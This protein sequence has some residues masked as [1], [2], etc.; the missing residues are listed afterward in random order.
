MADFDVQEIVES[1]KKKGINVSDKFEPMTKGQINFIFKLT[2]ISGEKNYVL[3]IGGSKAYE[4]ERFAK[5]EKLTKWLREHNI[6][7]PDYYDSGIVVFKDGSAHPYAVLEYVEGKEIDELAL[8]KYRDAVHESVALELIKLHKLSSEECYNLMG[9]QAFDGKK[10]WSDYL[11]GIIETSIRELVL[12][13]TSGKIPFLTSI[14]T[15]TLR[16]KFYNLFNKY[17]AV[18]ENTPLGVLHGDIHGRNFLI[19]NDQLKAILDF[20]HADLGDPAFDFV[21]YRQPFNPRLDI[22]LDL[23][24]KDDPTFNAAEF[25][26]RVIIYG[27]FKRLRQAA[28]YVHDGRLREAEDMLKDAWKLVN[29]L[30]SH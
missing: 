11:S 12:A 1:L 13:E 5:L 8:E 27:A 24:V 23:R 26:Q 22:Y 14:G 25:R 20:D 19:K 17:K 21:G 10:S 18:F 15:N 7:I 30:L 4:I 16:E 3:R 2:S 6:L 29:E 28:W 9:R